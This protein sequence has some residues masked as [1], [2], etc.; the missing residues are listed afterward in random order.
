[1]VGSDPL[2]PQHSWPYTVPS[3]RHVLNEGLSFSDLT[4]IVGENGAGK[5][6]LLESLADAYGFPLEGGTL[7]E[8]RDSVEGESAF[9]EHL[10]LV[11]GAAGTRDG[12]FFRA[13]TA[14]SFQT[15]LQG[16]GSPR[17]KKL[18]LQ[19]HGESALS[20]IESSKIGSGL[21]LFDEP[22]SGLSFQG[23]LFLINLLMEH[24]KGGGQ[25]ILCT[26][27]PLLMALDGA[28]LLEIG[29]WGIRQKTYEELET[30]TLWRSFLQSPGRFLRH[31]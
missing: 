6:V 16:Q 23:Q 30:I 9:G 18:L 10:Q 22:E 1:M 24:I 2:P 28:V 20:L 25:V 17:G 26:H 21:W 11:R 27:S 4:I 19:S 31:F 8:Q 29:D 15:Y 3:V 5:S 13:E 12:L 14:H 7:A